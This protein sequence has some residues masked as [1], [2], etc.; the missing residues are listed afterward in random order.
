[1]TK[2]LVD[3]FGPI[4]SRQ[5]AKKSGLKNY[6]TGKRCINGHLTQRNTKNKKCHYCLFVWKKNDVA[7]NERRHQREVAK[8]NQLKE[9][10]AGSSRPN[11]CDIC[12]DADKKIRWDHCH[13]TGKFRGWICTRC[14]CTFGY[15]ND[16]PELLRKMAEYLEENGEVERKEKKFP[17]SSR[18]RGA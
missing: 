12:G 7:G 5:E 6:F 3:Y 9:E 1:M 16:S 13:Y 4:V 10:I 18:F 17:S 2:E 14:N 11:V 8:R 15:V